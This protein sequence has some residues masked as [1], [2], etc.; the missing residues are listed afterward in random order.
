[1]AGLISTPRQPG[2]FSLLPEDDRL[3]QSPSFPEPQQILA[4]RRRLV[5]NWR[6]PDFT[7]DSHS[8]AFCLHGGSEGDDD[9]YVMINSYWD[10]LEF[11]IQEGTGK[12]W[13][14]IVDTSLN[15]PD[16]FSDQGMELEQVKRLVASRSIVVLLR[17]GH[18]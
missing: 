14:R 8:L 12:D 5:W 11:E 6:S 10:P 18:A 13:K 9:I 15:S 7:H 4:R 2:N 1:V 16:D 17:T 3:P